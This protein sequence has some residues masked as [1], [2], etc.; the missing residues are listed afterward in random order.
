MWTGLLLPLYVHHDG[1][2]DIDLGSSVSGSTR[3]PLA[4]IGTALGLPALCQHEL[5]CS[6][7]TAPTAP[8][9][10][11]ACG[12]LG[13]LVQNLI[14]ADFERHISHF[15]GDS[16]GADIPEDQALWLDETI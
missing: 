11:Y 10:V 12:E 8:E 13:F 14:A 4:D 7:D 3:T 6:L 15:S 5:P 16:Y 2:L 1:D 9:M